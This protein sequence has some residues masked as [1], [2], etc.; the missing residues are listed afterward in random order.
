MYKIKTYSKEQAKKLGVTIRESKNPKKKI[1]VY[2]D[3]EKVASI[4]ATGYKDFPTYVQTDGKQ[5]AEQR[6][7]LYKKRH[8]KDRNVKGTAGY[9]ADKILW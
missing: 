9:Y 4:G 6:R 1:D 2:K 3:G 8:A 7:A 5:Y